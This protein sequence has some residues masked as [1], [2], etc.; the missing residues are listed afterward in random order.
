VEATGDLLCKIVCFNQLFGDYLYYNFL[1]F[2]PFLFTVGDGS[3][4]PPLRSLH[5]SLC[6]SI[7]MVGQ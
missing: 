1:F 6:C 5:C 2:S 7:E 3:P 4:L